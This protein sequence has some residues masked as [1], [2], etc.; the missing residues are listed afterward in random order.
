MIFAIVAVNIVYKL[1]AVFYI[2][3]CCY[4][5]EIWVGS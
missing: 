3:I 4:Y 2:Y 5:Y 1:H